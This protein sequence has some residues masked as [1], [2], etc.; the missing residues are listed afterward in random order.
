MLE[1]HPALLLL[2]ALPTAAEAAAAALAAIAPRAAAAPAETLA[3]VHAALASAPELM[4]RLPGAVAWD[5]LTMEVQ[6]LF[7]EPWD[8]WGDWDERRAAYEKEW[9]GR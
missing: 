3:A 6:N 5:D 4:L 7:A 1:R 8:E 9:E 2:P